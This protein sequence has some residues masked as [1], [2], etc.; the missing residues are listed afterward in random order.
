MEHGVSPNTVTE[1]A[2]DRSGNVENAAVA[3]GINRGSFAIAASLL[4]LIALGAVSAALLSEGHVVGDGVDLFGTFWFYWWIADCVAQLRGPSFTDLMFFPL[5]KDIFAHTGD[6]FVDALVSVPFQWLLGFPR[7]QPVFV[8]FLLWGNGITFWWLARKLMGHGQ[9]AVIAAALWMV[10]PYVLFE[11]MTG[12]FTQA[13]VW[14]LPLA[15]LSYESIGERK[16]ASVGMGLFTALQAWTY[17]FM[18]YF[19]ALAFAWLFVVDW[20]S[21]HRDRRVLAKG[22]GIAACVCALLVLPAGWAMDG[23]ASSGDVPGLSPPGGVENWRDLLVPPGAMGNNVASFLHGYVLMER[24]GQPMFASLVWGGGLLVFVA[25]PAIGWLPRVRWA[26]LVMVALLFAVG[27]VWPKGGSVITGGEGWVMPHYMLAYHWLPFFDRLWFPYRLISIAFMG[28]AIAL[29]LLIN[30]VEKRWGKTWALGL[31]GGMLGIALWEQNAHLAYPLL[32][33]QMQPPDSMQV[34]GEAGGGLIELPLRTARVSIAWQAVHHQP[35]FGGMAENAP[36]LWPDGYR[37]R[38]RQ[39]FI[40]FL[41]VVA[42]DPTTELTTTMDEADGL[43]DE[44]FRWVVLD[45][46]LVDS[47]AHHSRYGRTASPEALAKLPFDVASRLEAVLG[48]PTMVDG[49]L[50]IWD[51]LD[52]VVVPQALSPSSDGQD[53]R[54][55][56]THDMPAYEEHLRSIGRLPAMEKEKP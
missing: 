16:W 50:V 55:W 48:P 8:G 23:L 30:A 29:G 44:G 38:L 7:Y 19:M 51:M 12:R 43:I 15:L 5:G 1:S 24:Q 52:T 18:G 49:A 20:V 45:R 17:W 25:A 22:V 33:R 26:G 21:G 39:P 6:N 35:T 46:H 41:D 37:A 47:N 3:Q 9:A 31:A 53:A 28:S 11:C 2:S 27:P 34:I 4:G 14:F 32:H 36:L 40:R 13:F 42:R 56:R 54:S 10:N